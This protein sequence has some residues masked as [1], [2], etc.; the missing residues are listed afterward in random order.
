MGSSLTRPELAWVLTSGV[1]LTV[2]AAVLLVS[3]SVLRRDS[4]ES[5][6]ARLI[7][8]MSLLLNRHEPRLLGLGGGGD[9]NPRS[10][11]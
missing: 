7:R 9:G 11:P 1:V 3:V 10:R 2:L 4:Q 5:S 8:L 6:F